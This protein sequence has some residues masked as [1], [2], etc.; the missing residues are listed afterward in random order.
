[1]LVEGALACL[2]ELPCDGSPGGPSLAGDNAPSLV[3]RA[4]WFPDEGGSWTD[5][6]N[7]QPTLEHY[8]DSFDDLTPAEYQTLCDSQGF[9]LAGAQYSRECYCG[10]TIIGNN[11]PSNRSVMS[12]AQEIPIKLVGGGYAINIYMKD[13]YRYT[14]GPPTLL[15]T[16]NSSENPRCR[17]VGTS[18]YGYPR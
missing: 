3:K 9:P 4:A 12:L 14:I 5:N 10:N 11:R 17:F 1:P 16:Y 15:N 13:N 6:A 2:S 8:L 7:N 18:L